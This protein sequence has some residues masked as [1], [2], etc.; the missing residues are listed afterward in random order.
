[1]AATDQDLA[2]REAARAR[3]FRLVK[4][5]RRKPG[6]D[7]GRYGLVGLDS[8]REC[9]GFGPDGLTATPDEVHAYLRGGEVAS[10]KRS[11]MGVV[12]EQPSKAAKTP[13]GTGPKQGAREAAATDRASPPAGAQNRKPS[14][15]SR[16]RLL[17]SLKNSEDKIEPPPAAAPQPQPIAIRD[18]TRRDAAALAKLLQIP[19][20]TLAERLASAIKAG[21]PPLMAMRGEQPVGVAAWTI[22]PT[23]HEGPRG[24]ITLLL[25]AEGERRQGT[26][27]VLLQSAERHL[28]EAGVAVVELLL[29]I[30]FDTPAAFL[31]RTGWERR[32][33]GYVKETQ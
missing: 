22:F 24:R 2:L 19:A 32:T 30:D 21:E 10:W 13:V 14:P 12:E 16:K 26:G 7:F 33:N 1:M 4:S 31:R 9:L 17:A 29:D 5:R 15:V 27:M 3:G 25:V 28:A 23:L 18:A 11:L 8:G 6:G 20:A